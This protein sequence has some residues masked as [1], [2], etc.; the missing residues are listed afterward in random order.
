MAG[1]IRRQSKETWEVTVDLGRDPV[2]KQRRRRSFTVRGKKCDAERALTAALAQRDRGIDVSPANITV[3]EYLRRWLRDYA[4][5]N[6]APSTLARYTGIVDHHL[7]PALGP[8]RLQ[9]LRPAHIQAAYARALAAGGRA[10][11]RQCG[12]AHRSVIQHHRVLREALRHAVEWQLLVTNPA[13]AVRPPRAERHELRVL[14]AEEAAQLLVAAHGTSHYL[15]S[16]W[17][18]RAARAWVS[19]SPFAGRTWIWT[20][21]P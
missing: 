4:T 8:I 5:H 12:L 20:P 6:V 9:E 14:D 2:T 21:V 3:G 11:G 15:L 16:T 7:I 19:C 1:S 10:D 13:S 17:R 18:S